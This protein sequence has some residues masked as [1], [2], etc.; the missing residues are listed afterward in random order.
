MGDIGVAVAVREVYRRCRSPALELA[1]HDRKLRPV[2]VSLGGIAA[3]A[4]GILLALAIAG[5]DVTRAT[6][7][8]QPDS[9]VPGSHEAAIFSPIGRKAVAVGLVMDRVR[10]VA[11]DHHYKVKTYVDETEIKAQ[12]IPPTD[13]DP[14]DATAANFLKL[15]EKGIVLIA[16]HNFVGG[17]LVEAYGDSAFRDRALA[18]YVGKAF[19]PGEL[20]ACNFRDHTQT[21]AFGICITPQG[22]QNHFKDKNTIV[23]VFACCSARLATAFNAREF[24][25]YDG[26]VDPQD[27]GFVKDTNLLWGRMH[28]EIDTG[29]NRPANFAFAAG[30]FTPGFRYVPRN[31]RLL[32]TVLSP[33]VRMREPLPD[34]TWPV[35]A[36]AVPGFVNFDAV[37]DTKIPPGQIISVKGCKARIKAN[38][39]WSTNFAFGFQLFINEPGEA[40]LRIDASKALGLRFDPK[41]QGLDG[42]LEGRVAGD[43]IGPNEDDFIWKIKCVQ[44]PTTGSTTVPTEPP[45][46]TTAPTGSTSVPPTTVETTTATTIDTGPTTTESVGSTTVGS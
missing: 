18:K 22:I 32:E 42:N 9:L 2:G 36:N 20:V 6:V 33:G 12:P 21:L 28:G 25:A 5:G 35:S 15:S 24:F 41:E 11:E 19:A 37:M 4:G 13:N 17:L 43:H 38:P 30:G 14:G 44:T 40:T 31:P 16:T 34:T 10:F 8:H 23:E 27:R 29:V 26:L 39:D 45:P 7:G 1:M 46:P 3:F